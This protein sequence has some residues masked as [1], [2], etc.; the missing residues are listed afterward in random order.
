MKAACIVAHPDDCVIFA[1]PF[2]D[3]YSDWSWHIFYLT[4]AQYHER[5]VEMKSYWYD[6]RKIPVTSLGYNDTHLDMEN[7]E[8]SFNKEFAEEELQHIAENYD[9][10]LTHNP[11]GDYGHI[12]HMF[13]SNAVT[14]SAKPIVYFANHSQANLEI[15]AQSKLNLEQFPLHKSVVQDFKDI[16]TGRYWVSDSARNILNGQA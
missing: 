11:D 12:H 4:Y 5:V 10:I 1:R 9:L 15:A 14:G 8:I 7:N 6:Q 2:I 3:C 16:D 13:V